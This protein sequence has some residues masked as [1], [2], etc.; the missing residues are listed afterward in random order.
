MTVLNNINRLKSTRKQLRNNCTQS[1]E[2]L[3]KYL[4]SSQLLWLKFRRQH[5]IWRYILDFYCPKLKL[6]IE[7]DGEIHNDRQEYDT[8]RTEFL[9][10]CSVMIIRFTNDQIEKDLVTTL[11]I[12]QKY[13]KQ[14]YDLK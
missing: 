12:L 7:L 4:Q 2:I 3:W 13:I 5:S 1:E 11:D 6:W 14:N 10:V 9:E 8:I